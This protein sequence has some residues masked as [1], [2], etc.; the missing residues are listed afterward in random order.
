MDS[1]KVA[2]MP[3]YRYYIYG[4][5]FFPV[6]ETTLRIDGK[7]VGT[8]INVENDF[9]LKGKGVSFRTEALAQLSPRSA[10][11]LTY[12]SV[13]RHG[14]SVLDRDFTYGDS[15]LNAGARLSSY[16]NIRFMGATYRY[17]VFYD[18]NWNV[19][20]TTGIRVL[21]L[22]VGATLDRNNGSVYSNSLSV[23]IPVLLIGIH[24]SAYITPRLLG[25]YSFEYFG[26]TVQGINGK[27]IDNR[28][29]LEYYLLK[30]FSLGCSFTNIKYMVT[31]FP[32]NSRFDGDV[33]YS[34]TGFALY[35]GARF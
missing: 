2:R 19:G 29:T 21:N 6:S 8:S 25:R 10:V 15:T 34:V 3:K 22:D 33:G 20:F 35:L 11:S 7:F 31:D 14:E 9:K 24:G 17:S 30:N 16:F 4:G 28:L 26:L 27:V 32:V 18:K 23:F 13:F 5:T 12:F 1:L